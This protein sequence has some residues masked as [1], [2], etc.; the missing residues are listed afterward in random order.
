M[1][2]IEP[3]SPGS[4]PGPTDQNVPA[5]ATASPSNPMNWPG[6]HWSNPFVDDGE[7]DR[8]LSPEKPPGSDVLFPTVALALEV[9]RTL[10]TSQASRILDFGS[11]S[12][13]FCLLGATVSEGIFVGI[14]ASSELISRAYRACGSQEVNR[15]HFRNT[16]VREIDFAS[17]SAFFFHD[18]SIENL[19][20]LPPEGQA[21]TA[22]GPLLNQ[23]FYRIRSRLESAPL[24]TRVVVY[25]LELPL[26]P[27]GYER[28]SHQRNGDRRLELWSKSG[29]SIRPSKLYS[30]SAA[31]LQTGGTWLQP[32]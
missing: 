19:A 14:E 28:L 11:G 17:F 29:R 13:K 22:T 2:H 10:S 12:G 7:I 8:I 27:A 6:G 23:Y 5:G 15:V 32:L 4:N 30:V 1:S 20:L 24:G 9:A 26:P 21:A 25:G 3:D 18:L 16:P 31:S